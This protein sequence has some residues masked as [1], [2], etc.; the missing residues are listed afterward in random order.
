M[1]LSLVQHARGA[2]RAVNGISFSV[3]R[4][5]T[6]GL[7]GESGCGKSVTLAL[8]HAPDR[9]PGAVDAGEVNFD[10]R[11]LLQLDEAEMRKI[12]GNDISMIFQEPMS[13]L[14]P[15]CTI[16][17]QIGEVSIAPGHE[18]QG[19]PRMGDRAAAAW[20]ASPIRARA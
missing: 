17:D 4:G 3:S 13:S 19:G 20:S 16:G 11:D 2:V 6:L 15:V 1:A 7:V 5:K 14:N 9:Q 12:R 10:G 8:D 18:A